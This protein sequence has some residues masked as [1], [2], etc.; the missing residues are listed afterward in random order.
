MENNQKLGAGIITISVLI[1]VVSGFSLIG[2]L[3]GI[4]MSGAVNE[5]LAE[6]GAQTLTTFDYV[7][8]LVLTIASMVAVV[9]ILKKNKIGVFAYFGVYAINLIHTGIIQGFSTGTVRTLLLVALY[10]FF[11]SK[12][13]E[14]YGFSTENTESL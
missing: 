11:I 14:L 3:A 4:F 2:I 7:V 12:K 9:L 6:V 1:L 10:A 13:K 5:V 8:S